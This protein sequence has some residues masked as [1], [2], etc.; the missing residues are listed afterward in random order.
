MEKTSIYHTGPIS[1]LATFSNKYVATAG[2]D[3][4]LILW[5][6]GTHIPLACGMHDHLV[7]QCHFSPDGALLVSASSDYT[8]RIWSV[9]DMRLL[10]AITVHAD[11]VSKAAYAPNGQMIATSSFDGTL[12]ISDPYGAFK[13]RLVGHTG[14]IENFAWSND[15]RTLKSC[16]MD[17]TIR[18][19]DTATGLCIAVQ[20]F[21]DIDVDTLVVLNNGA[22]FA[23]NSD[24]T[25]ACIDCAGN[26]EIVK[27]H[28]TAVKLLFVDPEQKRLV[29][30]GYD[31]KV[32]VWEINGSSLGVNL[33]TSNFPTCIWARSAAFLSDDLIAFATFGTTYATWDISSDSWDISR[34]KPT[35]GINAVCATSEGIYSIGDAGLLKKSGLQIFDLKTLCNFVL[36]REQT[37]FAGGQHGIVY[38][39]I[40]GKEI[41]KHNSPLNCAT[42]VE[43]DDD[44]Y[45]AVGAYSGDVIYINVNNTADCKKHKLH[46]GAIKGIEFRNGVLVTGT[47]DGEINYTNAELVKILDKV[48][49]AHDGI[50]NDLCCFK[51]GFA[52]VSRDLT[53]R[54][55]ETGS[56]S[57]EIFRTSHKNSIKCVAANKDGDLIATASYGGT[58]QV[59]DAKRKAWHGA[60]IRPT[61]AGISSLTWDDHNKAFVAGSYDGNLYQVIV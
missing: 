23:G 58:I 38:D 25:I 61:M 5:C 13:R 35:G 31:N 55:W 36:A 49:N 10:G 2:Y 32:N 34:V 57:P 14:L 56:N 18:T 45:L 12:A 26:V 15:S 42:F 54:L 41:Y 43:L 1:G 40:T 27:A 16:G 8:A 17:G 7:N 29:S 19:W 51:D 44:V 33:Q 46:S 20:E 3:N 53:L 52:T 21:Q 11:D 39:A 47:S 59:F 6:A 60:I 9:P 24:G 28:D 50:V 48:E 22:S 4:R 37:V 30:L